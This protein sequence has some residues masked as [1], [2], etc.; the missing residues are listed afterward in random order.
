MIT[1]LAWSTRFNGTLLLV[2]MKMTFWT[3]WTV[4]QFYWIQEKCWTLTQYTSTLKLMQRIIERYAASIVNEENLSM[5]ASDSLT[6][7]P[8]IE[9]HIF[10]SFHFCEIR[11]HS[12]LSRKY[13]TIKRNF[14]PLSSCWVPS[15]IFK[16][17]RKC[18]IL[19]PST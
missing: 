10:L 1:S 16:I 18:I 17:Y 14:S 4:L 15:K 3:I 2:E 11:L 7:A 8:S 5:D 19:H 12:F 13:L 6:A 9:T